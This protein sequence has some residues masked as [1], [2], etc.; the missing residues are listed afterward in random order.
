MNEVNSQEHTTHETFNQGNV[1]SSN[2]SKKNS[3]EDIGQII[4]QIQQYPSN[5]IEDHLA[6]IHVRVNNIEQV[7]RIQEAGESAKKN[8]IYYPITM[9]KKEHAEVTDEYTKY[10]P[11]NDVSKK[12]LIMGKL[13]SMDEK[14]VELEK[15]NESDE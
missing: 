6:Q 10:Y 15:G 4:K 1:I 3:F 7:N 12:L 9:L 11:M 13:Y 2:P 8:P 14:L 5:K